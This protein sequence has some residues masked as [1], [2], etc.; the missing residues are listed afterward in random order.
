MSLNWSDVSYS[1]YERPDL[2]SRWAMLRPMSGLGQ[3]SSGGKSKFFL[4]RGMFL[5]CPG[6]LWLCDLLL[7][8]RWPL[9]VPRT[10]SAPNI[11]LISLSGVRK[12]TSTERTPAMSACPDLPRL[13]PAAL[14]ADA[15]AAFSSFLKPNFSHRESMSSSA[16]TAMSSGLL[17]AMCFFFFFFFFFF[18]C[19]GVSLFTSSS[20]SSSL[21]SPL[22]SPSSLLQQSREK[23]MRAPCE[24]GAPPS[25]PEDEGDDSSATP[26]CATSSCC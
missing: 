16:A 23:P 5:P 24:A 9:L 12:L 10:A 13:L 7:W 1:K 25:S 21:S 20:C 3:P 22:P 11:R 4:S 6:P 19:R 2:V 14:L 18:C 26:S 15:S 8:P 17:P